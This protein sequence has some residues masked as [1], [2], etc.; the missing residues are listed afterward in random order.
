MILNKIPSKL[1]KGLPKKI[2]AF[3]QSDELSQP[4]CLQAFYRVLSDAYY[5]TSTK[6]L[7][8]LTDAHGMHFS[9]ILSGDC[10]L[11]VL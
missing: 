5:R 7:R 6:D 11:S 4:R 2:I 8:R 10:I 1:K 3:T 9:A